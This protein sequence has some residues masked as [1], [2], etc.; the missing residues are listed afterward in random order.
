MNGH[1]LMTRE[2]F[3]R[4]VLHSGEVTKIA[5]HLALVIFILS[6]G[7]NTIEASA[8]DL[9]RI[10]GWGRTAIVDHLTELE[11]F[12]KVTLGIG[13]G[14]TVFELQGVIEDAINAGIVAGSRT[15]NKSAASASRTQRRNSVR[16]AATKTD[17]KT[18]T[19]DSV[20]EPVAKADMSASRTENDDLASADR[21]QAEPR[22]CARAYMENPSGLDSSQKENKH[23]P[24][25]PS[26]DGPREGEE[27]VGHGVF[28]NC[29]TVR[30]LAFSI[31]LPA[32][33]MQ[34]ALSNLGL[35]K[36]E[37]EPVARQAAIAHALQW[38]AEIENGKT[39]DVVRNGN[40]VNV[41]RGSVIA[42]H[43]KRPA[44]RKQ[45]QKSFLP[46]F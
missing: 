42:M 31:S 13:R 14:K 22:A 6:E 39:P 30:H 36:R 11:I 33:T 21:T 46:R 8:R 23:T 20:H 35:S 19:N 24:L 18:D 26:V 34:L 2:E 28:V 25:P 41:I 1:N 10:T 45:Q 29:E 9:E 12:M 38:A 27:A 5:Q 7:K 40:L 4:S 44:P 16:P 3:L 32:L 37:A 43:N 15:E 17:T